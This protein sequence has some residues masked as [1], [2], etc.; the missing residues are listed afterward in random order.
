MSAEELETEI[1]KLV[2]DIKKQDFQGTDE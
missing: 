2:D 1:S